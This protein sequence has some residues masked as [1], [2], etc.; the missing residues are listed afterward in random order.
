MTPN[1]DFSIATSDQIQSELG[2]KLEKIRLARNLTQS[3]LA[4]EAGVTV[5]T[6]QRLE[7]GLGVSMDTFLRV[8]IALGLQGYL[9]T[10]LPDPS[11]R[12]VERVNQHGHERRRARPRKSKAEKGA[13]TWGDEQE[14]PS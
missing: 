8:M 11:V 5:L 9:Q 2:N 13:F 1:I 7:R 12:P 3:Q 10:L 4:Q 6:L 14:K